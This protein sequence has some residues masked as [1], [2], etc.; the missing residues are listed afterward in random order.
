M[1]VRSMIEEFADLDFEERQDS[2]AVNFL[3]ALLE[4]RLV[5]ELKLNA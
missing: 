1:G 3:K 5:L 2:N 4:I